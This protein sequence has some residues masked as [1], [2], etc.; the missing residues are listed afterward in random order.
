MTLEEALNSLAMADKN[1]GM[2]AEAFRLTI[3]K[4]EAELA[5]AYR[6]GDF[7]FHM[8]EAIKRGDLD[9]ADT[10]A[11]KG[12]E[13]IAADVARQ[14]ELEA[15]RVKLEF[16][17]PKCAQCDA[18]LE[19]HPYQCK[20]WGLCDKCVGDVDAGDP[21]EPI[22]PDTTTIDVEPGGVADLSGVKTRYVQLRVKVT[23]EGASTSAKI[24]DGEGNPVTFGPVTPA[25]FAIP[26][27][28]DPDPTW[29]PGASEIESAVLCEL[30]PA[31]VCHFC[32]KPGHTAETCPEIPF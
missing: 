20:L 18:P 24:T 15:V 6:A 8:R 27:P 12:R 22:A 16:F 10:W 26:T 13:L 30:G 29:K 2:D 14:Q 32:D 11:K 7:P 21:R 23:S 4:L 17:R 9:V 19:V 1:R 3:R 28:L 5:A 25:H 31:P